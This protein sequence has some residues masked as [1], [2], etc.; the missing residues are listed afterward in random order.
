M[1]P[2][3]KR[4]KQVFQEDLDFIILLF[5]QSF[6]TFCLIL[7]TRQIFEPFFCFNFEQSIALEKRSSVQP[8]P[9]TEKGKQKFS[10]YFFFTRKTFAFR[11]KHVRVEQKK[12]P[13]IFLLLLLCISLLVKMS[14]A[15]STS[16]RSDF[17]VFCVFYA[18][19]KID[20][21]KVLHSI[22]QM[23][24]YTALHSDAKSP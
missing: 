9:W 19:C 21:W 14:R 23:L 17:F 2:S 22:S 7:S 24:N 11:N 12:W 15:E 6:M 3:H 16:S 13:H 4:T 20:F 8:K 1:R 5:R 18:K 10:E